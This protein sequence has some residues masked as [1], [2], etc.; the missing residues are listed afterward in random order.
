MNYF[1]FVSAPIALGADRTICYSGYS[2]TLIT[3]CNHSYNP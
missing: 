1:M 2:L 3:S